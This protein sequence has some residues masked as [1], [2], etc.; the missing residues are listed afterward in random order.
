MTEFQSA[1]KFLAAY[2]SCYTP[3][4]PGYGVFRGIDTHLEPSLMHSLR[5]FRYLAVC[6]IFR[7]RYKEKY[8]NLV[9]F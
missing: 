8:S 5:V 2:L 6:V 9:K 3:V 4:N 1:E 7:A